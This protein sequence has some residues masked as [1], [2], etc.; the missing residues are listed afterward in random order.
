MGRA[1]SWAAAWAYALLTGPILGYVAAGRGFRLEWKEATFA[2]SI[3]CQR[4][5]ER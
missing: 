5:K 2:L 3:R 4:F 1:K